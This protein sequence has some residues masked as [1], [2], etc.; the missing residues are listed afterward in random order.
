[1]VDKP[2]RPKEFR[3]RRLQQTDAQPLAQKVL[4]LASEFEDIPIAIA[5]TTRSEPASR[6]S[7]QPKDAGGTSSSRAVGPDSVYLGTDE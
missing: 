5:P 1:M 2:G 4:A 3:F 7:R 6:S